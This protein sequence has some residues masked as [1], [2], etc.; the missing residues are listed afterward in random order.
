MRL[1]RR[2]G[3]LLLGAVL[4]GAL[5]VAAGG[6]TSSKTTLT[7]TA[8]TPDSTFS[9]GKST[10]AAYAKTDPSLLGLTDSTPVNVMIKYDFDATASYKGGVDGFAATSPSVTGKT[11]K[12]NAAAVT[13][14]EEHAD[15]VA[16]SITAAVKS[17]VPSAR[18]GTEFVTA[19]GGIAARVP[20]NKIDQILAVSGVDSIQKDSLNQPLDDN[21]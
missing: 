19:Y 6:A 13:A 3:M 11:L 14:Y 2:L 4:V 10:S 8:L 9:A 20:G 15:N 16:D 18:I 12:Q 7:A 5:G 1:S 17:A 21:T